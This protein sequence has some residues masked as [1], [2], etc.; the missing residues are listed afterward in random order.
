L[1]KELKLIELFNNDV[2][3]NNPVIEEYLEV[4]TNNLILNN[5]NLEDRLTF[6]SILN[7]SEI[8]RALEFLN[9]KIPFLKKKL[10]LELKSQL[11][12]ILNER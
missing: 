5:L 8:A 2:Q 9:E 4:F 11:K 12:E 1:L 6:Y 7:N 3:K 10:Y